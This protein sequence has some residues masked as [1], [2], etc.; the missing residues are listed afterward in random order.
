MVTDKKLGNFPDAKNELSKF[1]KQR[2]S[3]KAKTDLSE[4]EFE[5]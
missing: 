3:T 1:V 5:F 2:E 4:K